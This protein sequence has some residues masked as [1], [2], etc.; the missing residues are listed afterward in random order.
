MKVNINS[1]VGGEYIMSVE[2][3][4]LFEKNKKKDKTIVQQKMKKFTDEEMQNLQLVVA[5]KEIKNK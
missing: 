2:D 5:S 1:K 4:L 3:Y